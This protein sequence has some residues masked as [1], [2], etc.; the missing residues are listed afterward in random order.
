MHINK[1]I[2]KHQLRKL[3]TMQWSLCIPPA[4]YKVITMVLPDLVSADPLER[5]AAWRTFIDSPMADPYRVRKDK[6][7]LN[8][9]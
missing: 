7:K 5:N 4:D 1:E 9:R 6:S 8:M 2:R 3:E